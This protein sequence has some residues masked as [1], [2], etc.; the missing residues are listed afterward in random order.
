MRLLLFNKLRN[1]G[2]DFFIPLIVL[3]AL[4]AQLALANKSKWVMNADSI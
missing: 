3:F 2:L 1:V 4:R